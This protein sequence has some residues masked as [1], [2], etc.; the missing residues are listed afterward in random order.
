MPCFADYKKTKTLA[1]NNQPA[2]CIPRSARG[3]RSYTKHAAASLPTTFSSTL[4][5]DCFQASES[6]RRGWVSSSFKRWSQKTAGVPIYYPPPLRTEYS[7]NRKNTSSATGHNCI[8]ERNATYSESQSIPS[9]RFSPLLHVT[10]QKPRAEQ[11]N[12]D[13]PGTKQRAFEARIS[14]ENSTSSALRL[15][16]ICVSVRSAIKT[17]TPESDTRNTLQIACIHVQPT[18][19][20]C[21][22]KGVS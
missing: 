13:Q 9:G 7:K 2:P 5:Y 11:D 10:S 15:C 20:K 18:S 6:D 22:E 21:K 3:S 4:L 1:D 14:N 8:F 16:G 17:E 19:R 12:E